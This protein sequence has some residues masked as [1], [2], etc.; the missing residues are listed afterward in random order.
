MLNAVTYKVIKAVIK[1]NKKG[2]T[3]HSISIHSNLPVLN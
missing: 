3:D 1:A 2:V